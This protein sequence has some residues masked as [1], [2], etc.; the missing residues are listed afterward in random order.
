MSR[1]ILSEVRVWHRPS[2]GELKFRGMLIQEGWDPP[3][4]HV[5]LPM[6]AAALL[7]TVIGAR[8]AYGDWSIAWNVGSFFIALVALSRT[9]VGHASN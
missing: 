5:V 6:T 9:W 7:L 2:V 3:S 1:D 4:L 8:L